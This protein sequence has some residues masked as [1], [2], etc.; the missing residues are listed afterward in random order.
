VD[1][2]GSARPI[3][4]ES[5]RFQGRD[6]GITGPPSGTLTDRMAWVPLTRRS[7]VREKAVYDSS[8]APSHSTAQEG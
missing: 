6:R 1:Y 2:F 8:T 4:A 7:A 5:V 3:K